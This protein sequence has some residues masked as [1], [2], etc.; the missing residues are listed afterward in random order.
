[1]S[2]KVTYGLEDVHIAFK[3]VAQVKSI[4]VTHECDLDEEITVTV[5]GTPLGGSKA[6]QVNLGT[7]S[8]GTVSQVASVVC[9]ALNNHADVGAHYV[10]SHIA[11]V[12]YLTAKV[13]AE[14][15]GTLDIAFTPGTSGVTVGASAD[16][17]AG[18]TGWG[19]PTEIPGA[20]RLTPT[21]QG[22]ESTF[23]AD[24]GPYFV[25]TANNG[26]TAELEMA[27]VPDSILATMLGWKVD[28]N[29]ALIEDA[30]GS[31]TRFAL[32]GQVM[33]DDKNRRFVYYDCQAAR[34]AKEHS[35]KGETIEP[36]TD[37]LALTI[38]PIEIGGID[39]VKGVLEL[40]GTN[41]AAYNGFFSAVYLP[42]FS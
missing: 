4:E 2:N 22:Q 20:V 19:V 1:M 14:D 3:G 32:M 27:L 23:Y 38:F 26:Y 28:D 40:S 6:V 24:N 15:D 8:H 30:D 10:A 16:V 13:V 41:T 37:V 7:E 21:A 25:V 39:V 17:A 35:T 5:T 18:A 9:N 34:P 29:G 31:P 36:K 42:V 11:G 12:I 33:G